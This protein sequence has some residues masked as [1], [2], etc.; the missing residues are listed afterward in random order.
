MELSLTD[1]YR[2]GN[3]FLLS[4]LLRIRF[5]CWKHFG[6]DRGLPTTAWGN[7]LKNTIVQLGC[8]FV[9]YFNNKSQMICFKT[10]FNTHTAAATHISCFM[11]FCHKCDFPLCIWLVSY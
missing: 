4:R 8:I 2:S 9:I 5:S 11:S 7:S 6:T 10:N 3:A 1:H